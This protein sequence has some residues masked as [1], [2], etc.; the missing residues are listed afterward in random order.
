M[1]KKIRRTARTNA[2]VTF[3]RLFVVLSQAGRSVYNA[4][5]IANLMMKKFPATFKHVD[6]SEVQKSISAALSPSMHGKSR[7]C[8]NGIDVGFAEVVKRI[9]NGG[10]NHTMGFQY[11]GPTAT[12][13][14]Y[15]ENEYIFPETRRSY[16]K[17]GKTQPVVLGVHPADK[18]KQQKQPVK[19]TVDQVDIRI[20]GDVV[21]LSNLKGRTLVIEAA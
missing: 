12:S 20:D 11:I 5:Q 3:E 19:K 21:Y 9:P 6:I 7:I 1:I 15:S 10:L 17:K 16:K 18:P 14:G 8:I 4:R 13:I 2:L